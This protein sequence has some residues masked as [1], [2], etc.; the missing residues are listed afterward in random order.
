MAL[1]CSDAALQD[2]L[3]AVCAL[4][5]Q[6]LQHSSGTC[7]VLGQHKWSILVWPALTTDPSLGGNLHVW[8]DARGSAQ[9]LHVWSVRSLFSFASTSVTWEGQDGIVV[10]CNEKE[11]LL[12]NSLR[13]SS[14]FTFNDLVLL[15]DHYNHERPRNATRNELLKFLADA[16]SDGNEDYIS[17]VLN[18]DAKCSHKKTDEHDEELEEQEQLL[19]SVLDNMDEAEKDQ[20]EGVSAKVKTRKKLAKIS[21][22]KKLYKEKCLEEEAAQLGLVVFFPGSTAFF[23]LSTNYQIEAIN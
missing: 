12:K 19:E 14:A 9:W 5:G 16:V 15:A 20:F 10:I 7:L 1:K 22:W 3:L 2:G 4:P 11:P 13:Q 21:H 6:V 18:S 23:S 8:L 17:L